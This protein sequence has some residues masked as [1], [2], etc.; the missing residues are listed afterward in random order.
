MT[1]VTTCTCLILCILLFS[2]FSMLIFHC[3]RE[4]NGI[5]DAVKI[6]HGQLEQMNV[7]IRRE[8]CIPPKYLW[9]GLALANYTCFIDLSNQFNPSICL[10]M[11]INFSIA[12]ILILWF[13][14]IHRLKT[15]AGTCHFHLG[16]VLLKCC[17]CGCTHISVCY[18]QNGLGKNALF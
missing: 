1:G 18:V 17:Q 7:C 9:S 13:R 4:Q 5:Y 8:H 15:I 14:V 2:T 16:F 6:F 3:F 11:H 10:I 12:S